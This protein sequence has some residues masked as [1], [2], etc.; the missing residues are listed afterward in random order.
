MEAQKMQAS[1]ARDKLK[2]DLITRVYSD[3]YMEG[4]FKKL[5]H[6]VKAMITE[7]FDEQSP[8]LV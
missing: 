5:R 7:D 6:K 4:V 3:E 8:K 2:V 1:E